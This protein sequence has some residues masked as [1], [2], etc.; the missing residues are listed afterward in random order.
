MTHPRIRHSQQKREFIQSLIDQIR[1]SHLISA[2]EAVTLLKHITDTFSVKT[3]T[4][5]TT[6][7]KDLSNV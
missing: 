3:K 5:S 4:R 1:E 2:Y 7:K 6:T